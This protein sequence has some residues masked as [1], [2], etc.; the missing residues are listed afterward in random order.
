MNGI[1]ATNRIDEM[2]QPAPQVVGLIGDQ[3]HVW[4]ASF[5][6]ATDS[7]KNLKSFLGQDDLCHA[8]RIRYDFKRESFL[9]S[10]ILLR[11]LLSIYLDRD[12]GE[13]EIGFNPWGKPVLIEKSGRNALHF[14]LSRANELAV[15]AFSRNRQVGIDLEILR[16]I[17][18]AEDIIEHYFSDYEKEVFKTVQPERL[19]EVFLR[20]WTRKEAYIKAKG[21]GLSMPLDHFDVSVAA[22]QPAALLK[23]KDDPAEAA[24]WRLLDLH[25]APGCVAALAVEEFDWEPRFWT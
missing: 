4:A 9:A 13:I 15:F 21:T 25:P 19:S 1:S 16:P 23:V 2:W 6:Q 20:C 10:H 12:Q 5:Q 14:S 24:R 18:E 3:V 11:I 17:P 8:E 22:G 7:D